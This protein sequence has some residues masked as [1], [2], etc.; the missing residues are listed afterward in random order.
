MTLE[1]TPYGIYS[2]IKINPCE[3]EHI[4][5]MRSID[6]H[7]KE[8]NDNLFYLWY[9]VIGEGLIKLKLSR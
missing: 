8:N 2:T 3:D 5:V 7:N 9:R 1:K 6:Y 4:Q